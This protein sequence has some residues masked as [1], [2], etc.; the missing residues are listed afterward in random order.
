MSF[1]NADG[2]PVFD[3]DWITVELPLLVEPQSEAEGMIDL[4]EYKDQL[5]QDYATDSFYAS[6]LW[7]SDGSVW[8]DPYGRFAE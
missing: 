6:K 1:Y 2:E 5:L 3:T 4:E 8:E 7:Y